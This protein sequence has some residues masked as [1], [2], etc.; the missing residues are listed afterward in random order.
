[1]SING[2]GERNKYAL[3][4]SYL[5]QKGMMIAGGYNR[6]VVKASNVSDL[7]NWM[8]AGLDLFVSADKT[9]SSGN[10]TAM[11]G[12]GGIINQAIKMSPALPVYNEDGTYHINNLPATQTL[13][14][15]VAQAL[16]QENFN[17]M[18]RVFGN[19]F[20]NF[21]PIKDMN[22]KVSLGG[23]MRDVKSYYYDPTTTI[24]GGLS[25]G[26]AR[27]RVNN[28]QYLIN[29]YILSYKKSINKHKFDVV[30]GFTYEQNI[31]EHVGAGASNFFTDAYLYNNLVAAICCC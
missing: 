7:T 2:G 15:P 16:E 6:F 14:N 12:R 28:N 11:E 30:G 4:A 24:Y 3:S 1:M 10:N 8:E 27:L 31:Y 23:D 22:F 25:G 19:V 18:N 5:D 29:E 20:L 26:E 9:S 13:E 17:R 21:K